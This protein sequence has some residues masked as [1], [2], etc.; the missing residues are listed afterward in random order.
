M[1][2][3]NVLMCTG[4]RV[5]T[6]VRAS[7]VATPTV[8]ARVSACG[9]TAGGQQRWA[10]TLVSALRACGLNFNGG[11]GLTQRESKARAGKYA[12]RV[13]R[14]RGLGSVGGRHPV[15]ILP[16]CSSTLRT[17]F[18]RAYKPLVRRCQ[19]ERDPRGRTD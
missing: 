3:A 11:E 9:R 16:F 18:K 6:H 7:G 4:L 15:L 5:D 1:A 14:G 2:N 8:W 13:L 10:G 12:R 17:H 19:T